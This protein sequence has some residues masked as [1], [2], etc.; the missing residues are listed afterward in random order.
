M[1]TIKQFKAVVDHPS[2]YAVQWKAENNAKI[3][4]TFC[5]YAPEEIIW[6]AGALPYRIFGSETEISRAAQHLQS[7]CCS[8]VRGA[9]GEA[10]SGGLDFIDGTIFPH[11][12]DSI[13]R[14]SDIWR[15]NDRFD[16]HLDAVMPV[17][18]NSKSSLEYMIAVLGRLKNDLENAVGKK[19]D[20]SALKQSVDIFNRIRKNLKTLY[21]IRCE[22]PDT[23]SSSDIFTVVKASMIMDR[24]VFCTGLERLIE[25]IEYTHPVKHLE[26]KRI[27]VS[28]GLCTMP[29][30]FKTIEACNAH[31]VWDDLCTGGRYFDGSIDTQKPLIE[32]IAHRY[33]TRNACPAKHNGL[34]NRGKNLVD[35]VRRTRADGVVFVHLKFCDPHAFDYPYIKKMLENENIACMLFELEDRVLSSGQFK[36]RCEAFIEMI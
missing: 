6:A 27:V 5:S 15:M 10:L 16:F 3:V 4:G 2:E 24:K 20:P 25:E 12:C 30:L 34:E 18:L 35:L 7:Y 32:A 1:E 26:K 31:V 19:I 28:G 13:Q 17:K 22:N 11:T 29:D 9:L 21:Q 36:T 8:L 14:L 23:I 33:F